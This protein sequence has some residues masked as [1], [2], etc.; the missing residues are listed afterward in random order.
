[1]P[2][3]LKAAALEIVPSGPLHA[4]LLVPSS[5][6]YTNRALLLAALADGESRIRRPLQSDDT[7][8]MRAALNAFGI[9]VTETEGDLLVQGAGGCFTAPRE[10]VHCG[11]SGTTSRFLTAFA[12]L[13]DGETVLTGEPPLLRRPIAPLVEALEPLGIAVRYLGE[14]GYLPVA[15]KGPLRGGHTRIDATKSSQFLT[16]LLM[17][18]PY[19]QSEITLEVTG[20]SSRPYVEMTV[21]AMRKFG[22]SIEHADGNSYRIAAQQTYTMQDY[23]IEYDASSAAHIFALA[24]T[25]GGSVTILNAAPDTLQADARFVEYLAE[26]GCTVQ[27]DGEALTVQGASTLR[28]IQRDLNDTPDMVTPLAVLCAYAEGE[29]HIHN[30][31]IVRGHE[32]DR[33]SATATELHKLG[34]QVEETPDGLRIQ[35]GMRHGGRIGTYHDHRMAMSFAAAG[36][37]TPGVII[38]E[39]GCVSKTYPEFWNHLASMGIGLRVA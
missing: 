18:A 23:P 11:L 29:A 4:R 9:G 22:A 13:A 19:A 36:V 5:K 34:V 6:S 20:L 30:V 37:R 12:A 28:P 2:D 39:P 24:A 16:A 14:P 10:P 35:G 15:I 32:T 27:R 8:R 21:Q 33:L 25:S 26:M 38:E 31:A 1:M 3:Y 17:I 7:T